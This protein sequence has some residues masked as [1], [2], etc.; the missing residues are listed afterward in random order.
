MTI[1]EFLKSKEITPEELEDN[2]NFIR[3]INVDMIYHKGCPN[4]D[5]KLNF[6]NYPSS[7]WTSVNMC[8]A[9]G[10]IMITYVTDRMGGG[11]TDRVDVYKDK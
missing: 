10:T 4:C 8:V 2:F 9:C 7:A 11:N 1:S 3:R 6:Y 5:N